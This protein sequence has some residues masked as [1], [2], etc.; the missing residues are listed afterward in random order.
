MFNIKREF[1]CR[2]RV[3]KIFLFNLLEEKYFIVL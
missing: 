3:N 1:V 2:E